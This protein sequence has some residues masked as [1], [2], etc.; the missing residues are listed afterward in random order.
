MSYVMPLAELKTKRTGSIALTN[1]YLVYLLIQSHPSSRQ[2]SL[3][4]EI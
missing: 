2:A 1:Y 4:E 3:R